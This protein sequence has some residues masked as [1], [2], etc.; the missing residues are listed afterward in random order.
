MCA[1][2]ATP[3]TAID[4]CD[5]ST[6]T[7]FTYGPS[8]DTTY[9]VVRLIYL[10]D[11][12]RI[13]C[14]QASDACAIAIGNE[15][16]N[17]VVVPVSF[18]PE[19]GP[20]SEPKL[21]AEPV[22]GLREGDVV[23]VQGTDFRIRREQEG[24]ISVVQC[25]VDPAVGC[26]PGLSPSQGPVE[27]EGDGGFETDVTVTRRLFTPAGFVDCATID[28]G[29]E[30]QARTFTG[31]DPPAVALSFDPAGPVPAE[32]RLSLE[33]PGPIAPGEELVVRGTGLPP[34]TDIRLGVCPSSLDP[35]VAERCTYFASLPG[36]R[37]DD[38]GNLRIGPATLEPSTYFADCAAAP[39]ECYLGWVPP[40][41][42]AY[43][44]LDLTFEPS[45]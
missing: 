20:V 41:F 22:S 9:Q 2:D 39:G 28:P 4:R 23:N 13:D 32:P 29:C 31:A 15:Q 1:G 26:S 3:E 40:H 44:R 42:G 34:R 43:V 10:A 17:G 21:A 37:T 5:F 27:I 30:L 25:A 38:E 16:S 12:T 45:G 19:A 7:S 8:I 36:A 35:Q 24:S 6:W 11:G 18:D 33:P 14:A